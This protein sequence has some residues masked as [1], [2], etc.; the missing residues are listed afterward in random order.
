[1]NVT[2]IVKD[3][4][5]EAVYTD[6]EYAASISVDVIDCDTTDPETQE[7]VAEAVKAAEENLIQI[8]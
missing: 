6:S 7:Y 8:Y 4:R 2:I 5:V 1:M 3:G